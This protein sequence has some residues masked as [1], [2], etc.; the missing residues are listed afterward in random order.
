MSDIIYKILLAD[1]DED[2]CFLFEEALNALPI[3]FQLKKVFN[4]DDLC[5]YL[6]AENIVYP[7]IIFLDLNMPRKNGF[8]CLRL[9]KSNINVKHIPIVII[10]TSIDE[11]AILQ[12][13]NNDASQYIR[14]PDNFEILKNVIARALFVVAN[15]KYI[16]PPLEHFILN[17]Y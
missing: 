4:G 13:Y 15:K 2:D 12:V 16:K 6:L 11:T 1:D 10:S 9:I 14:K 7:D 17:K 5:T 3:E 8:E